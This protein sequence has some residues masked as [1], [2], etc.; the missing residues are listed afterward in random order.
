MLT[1]PS[2]PHGGRGV[3]FLADVVANAFPSPLMLLIRINEGWWRLH[4]CLLVRGWSGVVCVIWLNMVSKCEVTKV[5]GDDEEVTWVKAER[6]T[7][8]PH[9]EVKTVTPALLLAHCGTVTETRVLFLSCYDRNG[10]VSPSHLQNL[11]SYNTSQV[12][13]VLLEARIIG[14]TAL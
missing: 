2:P 11:G 12:C 8:F 3:L 4:G 10:S 7:L 14:S 13:E 9:H 6:L 1:L 5:L